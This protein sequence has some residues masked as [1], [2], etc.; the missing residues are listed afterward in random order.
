MSFDLFKMLQTI[1]LQII[2]CVRERERERERR[3]F[4]IK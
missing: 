2:V 3:G 1:H 4:G